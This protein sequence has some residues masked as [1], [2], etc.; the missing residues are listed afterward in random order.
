MLAVATAAASEPAA[1]GKP[2]AISGSATKAAAEAGKARPDEAEAQDAVLQT[3]PECAEDVCPLWSAAGV[4]PYAHISGKLHF[5]L[6]KEASKTAA[7]TW[8][9][10]CAGP[11][12]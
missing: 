12:W 2:V 6:G 11:T 10:V 5:L 7:S 3:R 8:W 4:L 1:D 9:C